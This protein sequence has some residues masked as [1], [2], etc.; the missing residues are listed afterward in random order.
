M[1]NLKERWEAFGWTVSVVDGH[2]VALMAQALSGFTEARKQ[3]HVILATTTFGKG[4]S[5]MEQGIPLTQTHLPVCPITWHYLPMS[6]S[7]YERAI[8]K[9]HGLS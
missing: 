3:P 9:L 1:S 2:S 8:S 4:V 7:E 5:F 6:D